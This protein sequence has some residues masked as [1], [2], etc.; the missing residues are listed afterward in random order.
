MSRLVLQ[1]SFKL[2]Q[3]H[4]NNALFH[5]RALFLK[6]VLSRRSRIKI[7]IKLT[8][9]HSS[10]CRSRTSHF[11]S[12]TIS[13][14]NFPRRASMPKT[15]GYIQVHSV[16]P[17]W[18]QKN[19]K[20]NSIPVRRVPLTCADR[21]CFNSHQLAAL[22]GDPQVNKLDRFPVFATIFQYWL[23]GPG[24]QVW[25]GLQSWPADV[26]RRGGQGSLYSEV[27]YPG[28]GWDW[29]QGSPCTVKSNVQGAWSPCTVKS[30]V[31]GGMVTLYGEVPCPGGSTRTR[32]IP[33]TVRSNA[34]WLM[35]IWNFPPVD[36]M[37]DRHNWKNPLLTTWF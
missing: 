16:A 19:W 9:S 24:E 20:Q 12:K 30:N 28:G 22:V 7:S 31:Q 35:V 8:V 3:I 17:Y 11:L 37:M 29:S 2:G 34:S 14:H 33:C 26:T 6:P 1:T 10:S 27:L 36:R 23:G 5:R 13:S 4:W 25:T 32:G 21:T 15:H 18:T